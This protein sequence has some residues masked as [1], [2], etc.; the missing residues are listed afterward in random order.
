MKRMTIL[1][2]VL[3]LLVPAALPLAAQDADTGTDEAT[4]DIEVVVELGAWDA[5]TED[6]QGLVAEYEPT[7][8][9]PDLGLLVRSHQPWG[10]FFFDARF[11]D[12]DDSDAVLDVDTAGRAVRSTTE[13]TKLLHRLDH[14]PLSNLA[15]VTDHGRVVQHT[16]LD[17]GADYDISYELL[18][19]RTEVQFPALPALTVAAGVRNQE[20]HGTRQSLAISHCATCHVYSQG[21]RV[22]QRDTGLSLEARYTGSVASVRASVSQRELRQVPAFLTL[23]YD[24]AL[25]PELRTPL[26]ENRVQ[27]DS[28]AGPQPVD[29]TPD[30]DKNVVRLDVLLPN[31]GGFALT[32]GGV[33][34]ETEN[35][36]T[37][38]T[39]DY[40]GYVAT[41]F[42]PIAKGWDVRWRGRSYEID[43]DATFVDIAEPLGVAGPQA[44]LTYREI[45]GFDPDFL[46]LSSANRDVIESKLDVGWNLPGTKTG[47]LVLSW[48]YEIVDREYF[49]VA[50]GR[51]PASSGERGE[52]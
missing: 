32:G 50:P 1:A 23:L 5:D 52:G 25:Q 36:F 16:D 2:S 40:T 4:A 18:T 13:W 41:A 3:L 30:V 31:L 44:G 34:Q 48:D 6:E 43:N 51:R 14:D 29:A 17:A 24:D 26:F 20:R 49:E 28:A 35:Q 9:G 19:H 11:R 45:Y 47:R 7:D 33:W 22:D 42:R 38:L 15:S 8:G 27:W 12:A 39:M 21:R 46:R 37:N 10:H